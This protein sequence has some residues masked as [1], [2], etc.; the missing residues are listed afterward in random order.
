MTPAAQL[1]D[2]ERLNAELKAT[3]QALAQ[4]LKHTGHAARCEGCGADIYWVRHFIPQGGSKW[5]PYNT[6][7]MNHFIDCPNRDEFRKKARKSDGR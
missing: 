5:V 7:G 3:R 4:L 1:L 2:V 6:R